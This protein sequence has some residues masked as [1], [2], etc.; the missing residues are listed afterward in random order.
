LDMDAF[1]HVVE[2]VENAKKEILGEDENKVWCKFLIP[3]L[4]LAFG[5]SLTRIWSNM[6]KKRSRVLSC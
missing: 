2:V 6:K 4:N 3:S 1:R 5:H